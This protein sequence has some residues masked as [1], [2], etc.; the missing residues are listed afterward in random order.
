MKKLLTALILAF[1]AI[2]T[3]AS[4]QTIKTNSNEEF[5]S[6]LHTMI[7]ESGEEISIAE[8][9]EFSSMRLVALSDNDFDFMGAETVL[10]DSDGMYVLKFSSVQEA[11]SAYNYYLTVGEVSAAP[12][13]TLN[14]TEDTEEST[15]LSWGADFIDAD[16]P[17]KALVAKYGTVDDMPVINIAVIDTG[18]DYTHTFLSGRIDYE[19]GYDYVNADDD[20][21]DDHGHGTHVAGIICDSTLA[22]VKIIPFKSMDSSG[23]GTLSDM[24]TAVKQAKAVGAD[25]INMSIGGTDSNQAAKNATQSIFDELVEDG[26]IVVAAAGNLA[27]DAKNN[28]P[29]NIESVVTVSACAS[30]GTFASS[31]S[32]YGSLIDLCAPGTKIYSTVLNGAYGYKSGTS[33]ACPFVSAAAAMVEA[34]YYDDTDVDVIEALENAATAQSATDYYG[35]G[36][37]NLSAFAPESEEASPTPT[38]E[39]TEDPTSTPTVE[40]TEEPTSTP[41]VEP[42][43]EPTS[44]P[45]VEPT[46]EP[47]STPTVEPTEDP[48]STP[49]VEP[50]EEPTVTPTSEPTEEPTATPEPTSTQTPEPADEPIETAAPSPTAE[51]ALE[52]TA[53]PTEIP[54]EEPTATPEP[55][56]EPTPTPTFSAEVSLDGEKL[57][58]TVLNADEG[59]AV[60]AAIYASD[61][62]LIALHFGID[63]E[64]FEFTAENAA[65]AAVM[66]WD[67]PE[68]MLPLA[69]TVRIDIEK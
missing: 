14:I 13:I 8:E 29:A 45:T 58:I 39:P 26:I 16:A 6:A 33:M 15:H 55:T 62:T 50:T 12:D 9:N 35:Y 66:E 51:P 46:E 36:L 54:A 57:Y 21:M 60:I 4:A 52:A 34:L 47:T 41:T 30:D 37:L 1:A 56:A 49:T 3:T 27:T 69:D 32:N 23:S 42:T 31:Y 68:N 5:A 2:S 28:Y 17:A 64:T 65:Y 63:A 44:T 19:N 22:N 59:A 38:V 20:P 24:I 48:T 7:C 11:E 40:P 61:G 53:S 18:V 67:S 10:C 25:I 43:E